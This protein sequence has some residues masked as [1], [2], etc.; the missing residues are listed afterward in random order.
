MG[1]ELRNV[2]SGLKWD[3]MAGDFRRISD[4]RRPVNANIGPEN[5]RYMGGGLDQFHLQNQ[6]KGMP[7]WDD[8]IG[9]AHV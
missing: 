4:G 6:F 1:T 8:Q 7:I 9:R 5:S 2:H 3:P